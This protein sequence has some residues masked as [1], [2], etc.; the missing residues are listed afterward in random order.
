MPLTAEQETEIH[1]WLQEAANG[2]GLVKHMSQVYATLQQCGLLTKDQ[3]IPCKMVGVHHKNRDGLGLNS[4]HCHDLLVNVAELG[5]SAAEAHGIVVE[6]GSDQ[7]SAHVRQFNQ[8]LVEKSGGKSL[9]CENFVIVLA[10]LGYTS[11]MCLEMFCYGKF[12]PFC[13]WNKPFLFSHHVPLIYHHI[14]L[15]NH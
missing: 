5:W 12:G 15:S 11:V 7:H 14:Y 4:D 6:L 1:G 13:P 2:N 10:L 8:Q 9:T 3:R